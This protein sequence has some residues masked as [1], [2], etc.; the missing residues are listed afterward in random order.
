[1]SL[2][3]TGMTRLLRNALASSVVL[4]TIWLAHS[5]LAQQ[6]PPSLAALGE[7][8]PENEAL[9]GRTGRWAVT[10]TVWERPGAKPVAMTGLV[11]ERRMIGSMLQEVLRA[12][13]DAAGQDIKR[14]DCLRFNWVEGRWDYVS[15]EMRAPV[16]LMPAWSFDRG[17]DARI[18]FT[19]TPFAIA[20]AETV[21]QIL[22]MTHT[23]GTS[24]TVALS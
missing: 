21:G 17:E 9:A 13:K 10:E 14:M 24:T 15:M 6:A 19:S 2:E 3:P 5:V 16:R 8:G 20:G 7:L 4:G 22:R 12:E 23:S 1:M 18:E 11:A